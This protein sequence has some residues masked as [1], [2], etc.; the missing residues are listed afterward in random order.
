MTDAPPIGVR[1]NSPDDAV[2]EPP[3]VRRSIA[4]PELL[5]ARHRT[6]T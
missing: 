2:T 6:P 3:I 1:G 4:W 5:G